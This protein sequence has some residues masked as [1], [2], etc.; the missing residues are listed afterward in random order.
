ML[1]PSKPLFGYWQTDKYNFASHFTA[2]KAGLFYCK[3]DPDIVY[4]MW[5]AQEDA[6][7]QIRGASSCKQC[8]GIT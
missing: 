4:K 6:G 3:L 1:C 8:L 5:H 7:P 2:A